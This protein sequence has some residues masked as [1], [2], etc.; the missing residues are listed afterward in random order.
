VLRKGAT[1]KVVREHFANQN[2]DLLLQRVIV[3][4]FDLVGAAI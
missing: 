1:P 2:T 4:A 3:R